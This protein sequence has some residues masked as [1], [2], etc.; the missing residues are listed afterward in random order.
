MKMKKLF[1][2]GAAFALMAGMGITATA[3]GQNLF[4][5]RTMKPEM[6]WYHHTGHLQRHMGGRDCTAS[7][8]LGGFCGLTGTNG[9]HH[10]ETDVDCW[11]D[12]QTGSG[13]SC[14]TGNQCGA[15]VGTDGSGSCHIADGYCMN[16]ADADGDALC[17]V[18]GNPVCHDNAVTAAGNGGVS[19]QN[20][21]SVLPQNNGGV[22]QQA[23]LKGGLT[24][25]ETDN[26]GVT[27]SQGQ[28]YSGY[29]TG[30]HGSNY[31][32]CSSRTGHHGSG[33]HR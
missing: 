7:G 31:G 20:S 23:D 33:H 14:Y 4:V 24:D 28:S 21:G 26:D 9:I 22:S 6:A 16:W 18:C 1:I 8:D 27:G 17:D 15:I 32:G 3:S 30:C 11:T 10:S 19:S 13:K 25:S 5:T 29:S 12:G 2:T